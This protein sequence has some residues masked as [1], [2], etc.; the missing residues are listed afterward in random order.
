MSFLWIASLVGSRL[1]LQ[2][3]I[4]Q[5]CEISF[6]ATDQYVALVN[7]NR[8]TIQRIPF[9]RTRNTQSGVALVERAMRVAHQIPPVLADKLIADK[10]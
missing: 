1:A 2:I 4:S 10:I 5:V 7:A 3:S 8:Q 9:T 6:G